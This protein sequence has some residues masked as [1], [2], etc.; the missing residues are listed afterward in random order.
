MDK[1]Q[2]FIDFV[3]KIINTTPNLK[4]PD[5]ARVYFEALKNDKNSSKPMFTENGKLI[6]RFLKDN[7][8][9]ELWKAKDIAERLFISSR[10]ASGAMRKLVSDGFVEKIGTNP[11]IYTITQKGK[12]IEI[13]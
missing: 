9:T 10:T 7:L 2:E 1:R 12:E 3:E 5:G 6:L 8:D 4:M 13:D 11:V